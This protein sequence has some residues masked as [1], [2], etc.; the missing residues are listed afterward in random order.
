MSRI[1]IG[2]QVPPQRVCSD[3]S[4]CFSHSQ[5][6]ASADVALLREGL[7]VSIKLQDG[8]HQRVQPIEAPPHIARRR[9]QVHPHAGRQVHHRGSRKTLKTTR[10]A[11]GSTPGPTRNRS[12]VASM[13]STVAVS[14]HAFALVSTSANFTGS[15]LAKRFRHS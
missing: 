4:S 1:N 11:A 13:T 6:I 3:A 5:T 7:M 14:A 8:V 15:S 9:R 10:N 12:P 2:I